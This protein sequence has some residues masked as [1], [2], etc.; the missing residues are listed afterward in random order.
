M[1]Q[2]KYLKAIYSDLNNI[3]Y[4]MLDDFFSE[5]VTKIAEFKKD[6]N[7]IEKASS[8]R[9]RKIFESVYIKYATDHNYESGFFFKKNYDLGEGWTAFLDAYRDGKVKNLQEWVAKRRRIKTPKKKKTA[10]TIKPI[11]S[12]CDS[13]KTREYWEELLDGEDDEAVKDFIKYI[14]EIKC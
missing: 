9:D 5:A 14:K 12:Y 2:I 4:L 1:K 8:L 6:L 11:D 13:K 10:N 3:A 7:F